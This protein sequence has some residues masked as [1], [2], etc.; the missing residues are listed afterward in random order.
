MNSAIE[1]IVLGVL[2]SFIYSLLVYSFKRIGLYN[3]ARGVGL[4]IGI[5]M[6]LVLLGV[7]IFILWSLW[8]VSGLSLVSYGFIVAG[9]W[10]G[11]QFLLVVVFV[12]RD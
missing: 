5:I 11:V 1:S 7:L 8:V 12:W 2:S 4:L 6:N 3:F 10:G 9:I